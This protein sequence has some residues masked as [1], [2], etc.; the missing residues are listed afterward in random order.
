MR[1]ILVIAPHP[2]DET[3]GCGGTILKHKAQGGSIFWMVVTNILMKEGYTAEV[4]DRRQQEI[5]AVAKEYGFTKTF[6]LDFPTIKLDTLPL[7]DL[8][9]KINRVII[10]VQPNII[11]LP[12]ESDVHSDHRITFDASIGA[13][14]T[15]RT[16]TVKKVVMYETVSETEF[17]PALRDRIFAPNSFSD[18]SDYLDKKIA[19]MEIYKDQLGRHP[20]PRNIDNIKALATFRGATAGVKYAEAFTILKEIC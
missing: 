3:L 2:D 6:K 14:K 9:E 16:P 13:M 12:N 5:D 20:F 15:F 17:T 19:I 11:Y 18:V 4:I 7:W 8:I 1:N 10:E